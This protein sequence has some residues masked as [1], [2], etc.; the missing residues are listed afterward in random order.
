[1]EKVKIGSAT[2]E[3]VIRI[4]G[5]VK[6]IIILTDEFEGEQY[7]VWFSQKG[8]RVSISCFESVGEYKSRTD[9]VPNRFLTSEIWK[10][11]RGIFSENKKARLR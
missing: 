6:T 8:K 4:N 7:K 1:M 9:W 11:V 5:L 2:I 10:R 3:E